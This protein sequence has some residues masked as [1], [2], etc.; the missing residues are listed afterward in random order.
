MGVN[1]LKHISISI[2][3]LIIVGGAA[4]LFTRSTDTKGLSAEDYKFTDVFVEMA[5]AREMAGNDLDSLNVL[6][7]N[8]F[9]QNN[10]DSLWLLG[11]I[12]NISLDVEKHKLIWDVIIEKLDSLKRN[13]D[14]D[15]S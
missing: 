5:L 1:R 2:L 14:A 11:Y 13:P 9:E 7:T 8:I 3:F 12:S 6:Y 15:S 10:I 4:I